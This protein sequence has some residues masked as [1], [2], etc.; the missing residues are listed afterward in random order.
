MDNWQEWRRMQRSSLITRRKTVTEQE[1]KVWSEAITHS[2]KVGFPLLCNKCIGIYWP[3]R[4]EYDPR[5][6]ANYFYK[7]GATL[8]LPEVV[9]QQSPLRFLKWWPT[10]PMKKGAYQVPVPDN[11]APVTIDAVIIPMLGF[12]QKGFR[13]GYGS[14][15]FDRTLA[16][17]KP[18]PLVIGIAFELSRLNSVYPQSHDIPMDFI[19]TEEGIHQATK[20]ELRMITPNKCVA[21]T[22]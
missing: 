18:Y 4:N 11:T 1:H 14:G 13:L 9:N 12:D 15:Y 20:N 2:L 6:A 3:I 8:A 22:T 17:I 5:P 10:A 21:I 16:E 19:I 7:R